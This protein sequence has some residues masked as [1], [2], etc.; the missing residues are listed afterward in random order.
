MSEKSLPPVPQSIALVPQC[1]DANLHGTPEDVQQRNRP[2]ELGSLAQT[3]RQ[4]HRDKPPVEHTGPSAIRGDQRD[5]EPIGLSPST[6]KHMDH[7]DRSYDRGT[8][9]SGIFK[10]VGER[11]SIK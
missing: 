2:G 5:R 10:N 6:S 4:P 7:P 1:E 11:C 8:K 9:G 3:E